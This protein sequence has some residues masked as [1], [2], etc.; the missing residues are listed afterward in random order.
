VQDWPPKPSK[1]NLLPFYASPVQMKI[2]RELPH[3]LN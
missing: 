1:K 2:E 3:L